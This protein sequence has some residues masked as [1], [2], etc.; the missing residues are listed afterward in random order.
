MG[1]FVFCLRPD[2]FLP[3]G[4]DE[5]YARMDE[6]VARMKACP[7]TQAAEGGS[8]GGGGGGVLMP[9]EP[10][11]ITQAQRT[12]EGFPL[13]DAVLEQTVLLPSP[14]TPRRSRP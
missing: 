11:S 9:G 5:Y 7:P 2:L 3:G 6:F 1:H 14:H 12:A 8:A 10:E 13:P 4:L